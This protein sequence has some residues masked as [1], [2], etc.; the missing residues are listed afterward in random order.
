MRE[1]ILSNIDKSR[2]NDLFKKLDNLGIKVI[3]HDY[4]FDLRIDFVQI[5]S[6]EDDKKINEYIW[7]FPVQGFI[8]ITNDDPYGHYSTMLF[9]SFVIKAIYEIFEIYK[10]YNP[11]YAFQYK[12]EEEALSIREIGLSIRP[13]NCLIRAGIETVDDL[14]MRSD[15]PY[16]MSKMR[17]MGEVSIKE[18]VDK[19]HEL[20]YRFLYEA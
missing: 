16:F 15:N 19:I 18:V 3:L 14:I 4:F 5:V 13:L 20:G 1:I 7:I 6:D 2:L 17:N 9:D 8:K 12:A 10:R 11:D